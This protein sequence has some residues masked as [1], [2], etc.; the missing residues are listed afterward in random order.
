[1][2]GFDWGEFVQSSTRI[3]N[4]SRKPNWTEYKVIAKVTGIG[5]ILIGVI[6]FTVKLLMEGFLRL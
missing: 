4:V 5:I 1:M 3:F 2:F 6:G